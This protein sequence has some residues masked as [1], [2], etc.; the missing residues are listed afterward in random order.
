SHVGGFL[1]SDGEGRGSG[2]VEI[3]EGGAV[4]SGGKNC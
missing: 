1:G 2:G 3:G 4:K